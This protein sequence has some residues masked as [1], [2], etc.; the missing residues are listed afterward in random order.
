MQPTHEV[1]SESRLTAFREIPVIDISALMDRTAPDHVARQIAAA[2]EEVGFFYAINHGVS[3]ELIS[4]MFKAAE[5]LF[6]LSWDTKQHLDMANSGLTRR[7]YCASRW[8]DENSGRALDFKESFDYGAESDEILPFFGN[9]IMPSELPGFRETAGT[10]YE[11]MRQVAGRLS[12]GIALSL[13]LPSDYFDHLQRDP[14]TNQRILRY[15]A[16]Q[17]QAGTADRETGA[18]TDFGFLTV[19]AQDNA[20]A[21]ELQNRD[22]DWVG[23]IPVTG[24]L[25]IGVGELLSSMTNRRYSSTVHR[26]V[27]RGTGPHFALSFFLDLD[28]HAVVEPVPTC[29]DDSQEEDTPLMTCGQYKY[30]HYLDTQRQLSW[31]RPKPPSALS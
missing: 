5:Q 1:R 14:I 6:G 12:G 2:C 25:L 29:I 22:G 24:S 7:G 26:V 23:T 18:H 15:P 16:L 20:G 19:L 13:G 30:G 27:N 11:A 17:G 3:D 31:S 8:E 4:S 9:N 28:F 10:Y 21:L